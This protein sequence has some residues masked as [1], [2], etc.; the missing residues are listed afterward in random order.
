MPE[1]DDDASRADAA[2]DRAERAENAAVDA[3]HAAQAARADSMRSRIRAEGAA[4]MLRRAMRRSSQAKP[5]DLLI[6]PDGGAGNASSNPYGTPGPA[7]SRRS[8]FFIGFV[9]TLGVLLALL[10]GMA[11]QQARSPLVLIVV[12][13]FLAVG[14][15]PIVEFLIHRG[16]RRSFSVLTVTLGV[17]AVITLFVVALVPVLRDQIEALIDNAPGWL[18]QLQG[19]K[20]VQSLDEKYDVISTVQERLQDGTVAQQ[21]F[22]SIFTVGIAVL[23]GLLNAFFVFVLTVYF[24]S[25]LPAI[26]RA[27]YSLAPVRRRERVQSLGD[28]ILRRVG[29]YV[30][31][32]FVIALIAGVSSFIFLEFAGLAQYALALSLVVAILDFIPLIGATIGATIVTLIAFATSLETGISCAVFYLIYQ[33]IENYVIYPRVMRSSVELPGVVTVIAVLIGGTLMGVVGALLA[34]PTAAAVLLLI[35]ETVVRRNDAEA[36]PGVTV[37]EASSTRGNADPEPS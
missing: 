7:L 33:Q 26:K 8:P 18:D 3:R 34:I 21:A 23:N 20:Q 27:C 32:A 10:L 4:Q 31:G 35:R 2:A 37:D 5:D 29:G 9:G 16:V 12:S 17:V 24:L 25:A 28:E 6:H 22:G 36:A 30:A 1:P 13:M 19:N 15:N 11:I 14:L